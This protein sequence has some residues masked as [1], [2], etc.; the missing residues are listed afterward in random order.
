MLAASGVEVIVGIVAR[1][2]TKKA[3][4]HCY[5]AALQ[6]SCQCYCGCI[7]L[8]TSVSPCD[9]QKLAAGGCTC[10][11]MTHVQRQRQGQ[12]AV[13]RLV[14]K[15]VIQF[16]RASERQE[17]TPDGQRV[18]NAKSAVKAVRLPLS[19]GARHGLCRPYQTFSNTNGSLNNACSLTLLG[20][21][22][23]SQ[24]SQTQR[25]QDDAPAHGD[26]EA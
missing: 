14:L 24:D 18:C 9:L 21:H 3:G 15:D 12:Q 13:T 26:H 4:Q 22:S 8:L 16:Q 17:T 2:S 5:S 7:S 6:F 23:R 11:T 10:A 1:L 19:L 25:Q 20:G